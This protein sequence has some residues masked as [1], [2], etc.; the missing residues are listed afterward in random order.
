V[1]FSR[2]ELDA[3]RSETLGDVIRTDVKL[4]FVGINP[5]LL[6]VALK[7][8]FPGRNRFYAALHAAGITDRR[9]D[10]STGLAAED[11][12]YLGECGVGITSL[13]ARA[14]ARADELSRDELTAA[15]G[16]LIDKVARLQ[17]A[18]VAI[19]GITAYRIAFAE[20]HADFGR[21]ERE[22]A[23][24]PVFVLPNPSGR[25][26]HAP[27]PVLASSYR[28]AAIAAGINVLPDLPP[29]PR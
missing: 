22:I 20:P 29:R 6:A 8:P 2:A 19:L 13:V 24:R 26:F 17:P 1:R 18:L 23:D 4:L 9:I 11:R 27:L 10:V 5:G 7:A 16:S 25:N 21:Q 28:E 12:N 15:I 3:F 14:T